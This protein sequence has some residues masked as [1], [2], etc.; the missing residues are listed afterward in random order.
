MSAFYESDEG[1]NQYLLFHYG[2]AD[3]VLPY[4]FGPKES[5]NFP[6]RCVAELVDRERMSSGEALALDLGCA[7]GRSSFELSKIAASVVSIDY[8]SRFIEAARHLKDTGEIEF[9][10]ALEGQI[11]RGFYYSLPA[12]VHASRVHFE[13]GDA[14]NLREDLGQFDL[15]LAANLLCRLAEPKKL[16]RRLRDLLRP[17]GQLVF[18]TPCSWLEEYTPRENWLGGYVEGGQEVRTIAS[19]RELLSDSFECEFVRDF[20]MLIP[21]HSRKFQWTVT[22]ASRWLRRDF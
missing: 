22:Q 20:P 4:D 11:T 5:L 7:V 16:L 21:E 3:E 19:L 2:S 6:V 15:V 8:S 9:S 10:S 12:D 13:V 18:T 1:L 14:Q 17:G